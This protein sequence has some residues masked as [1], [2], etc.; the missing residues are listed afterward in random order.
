MPAVSPV[1]RARGRRRVCSGGAA[2]FVAAAP[3]LLWQTPLAAAATAGTR[4]IT[5]IA[6]AEWDGVGGRTLASVQRSNEVRIAMGWRSLV[7]P[8]EPA[9]DEGAVDIT[10][11]AARTEAA[12]GD[13]VRYQ[14]TLRNAETDRTIVAVRLRDALPEVMRLRPGS[15]KVVGATGGLAFRAD[16]RGFTL[17]LPAMP[18]AATVTVSYAAEVRAD[19]RPGAAVNVA[20]VEGGARQASANAVV[21]IAGDEIA[22]RL[23]IIGRVSTGPCPLR[24]APGVPNVRVMLEDGSY[25]VTD[26]DGRYHFEGVRPGLHVV[27]AD[28][29]TLTSGQRF[30]D[31]ERNTRAA[32]RGYSRFVEG[33]GGALKRVDFRVEGTPGLAASATAPGHAPTHPPRPAVAAD[34]AAAGGETDWLVD[35]RP[36]VEWL[37]PA[38]DHNPRA[39]VVRVAIKHL[40]GQKL[41]LFRD[42]RPVDASAFD[43][44]RTSADGLVAISTW[45]GVAFDKGRTRL[46]AEVADANGA[47]VQRLTRDVHFSAAP[48]F[49]QLVPERSRLVA[50]GV[51][52]PV[53]AVRFTDRR[54]RPVHHG[55]VGAFAVPAPYYPAVAADA[56]QARQLAGLER[57]PPAWRVQGDDGVAYLE[58]EPTTASG[59]LPV[60]FDFQDG[61]RR[62][63]QRLDLWLQPGR[64]AWTVVGVAEGTVAHRRLSRGIE[65]RA[66]DGE[67][68]LTDGR[69]A[70]YAKGRVRGKWLL[71]LSYDSDKREDETRFPGVIDPDAYYTVYADRSER[72]YDAASVR[73]LYL[74]IERPQF[75]ALFG[76]YLTGLDEPQLTRYARALNGGKAE[77]RGRRVAATAFAA[78]VAT[79]HRRAELQGDGLSGPYL[80]GAGSILPNSEVVR[81]EVRDRLRSDRIVETRPLVRYANYDIDYRRG[82][83]R[84]KAPLLSRTSGLDPQFLVVDYEVDGVAGRRWHAGGRATVRAMSDRLQLGATAFRDAGEATLAE[85][86]AGA[87]L[88]GGADVR[89][90]PTPATELRA[91]AAV[92]RRE[93]EDIASALLVEAEHHGP[94]VDLL[95]YARRQESGFGVGQ[96]NRAEQGRQ[97]IGADGRVRL[98][99]RLAIFASG[100]T[101]RELDGDARRLAARARVEYAGEERSLRAGL[102]FADD[103]LRDGRG[104]RSTLLE[105]GGTQ[106]LLNNRLELDATSELAL[107]G[108]ASVDFPS[109]HVFSARFRATDYA[110]LVAGY[111]IAD[112]D[113]VSARTARLGFDL[114]PW[115]GARFAASANRQDIAEYGPRS[116][117]AFGLAQSLQLDARWTVDASVDANR[118][119]GGV[120]PARVLNPDQPVATGGFVGD[121]SLFTEDFTAVTAGATYRAGRWSAT[122]RAEYRAGDLGDR[123][124][125][126]L[127]AIR[128]LGEGSAA[129]GL[130]TFFDASGSDGAA[131]RA[132]H[133]QL[134]WAHRPANNGWSWLEKLE[135]HEDRVSNASVGSP[136][137]SIGGLFGVAGDLRSRRLVNSL[138]VHRTSGDAELALFWGSRY[139]S[140]RLGDDDVKGW[141][142]LFGADLRFDLSS[143]VDLGLA[144]TF[145]Q[146]AGDRSRAFAVGPTIGLSPL[147]NGWLQLGWNLLGFRDRDFGDTRYTRSGPFATMRLKF[148]QLSLSG[149]GR[150]AATR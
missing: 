82:T 97:K 150:G 93:G 41:R 109:R 23:T 37:F 87:T 48:L 17:N 28:P 66:D 91:E 139:A 123:H 19:A 13:L 114:K 107:D 98:T 25:A 78:D 92:S 61:D 64:G 27:Q 44:V 50:D 10:K 145:R 128:Q 30:I 90:R 15:L 14:I 59:A 116:F 52:R 4:Y 65:R 54:G 137:P 135:I 85:G 101:E 124:G 47:L 141:S 84:L 35:Q 69:L 102:I 89:Y 79:R 120:G 110:T 53:I 63:R 70:L 6:R 39:P 83:I 45:R 143:R 5:N 106:R 113:A 105:L 12:P 131:A 34:G 146:G 31:C 130:L 126:T 22:E 94:R 2:L 9:A 117:A 127:G 20:T 88:V 111:E 21:R 18:R 57:T 76:D 96:T 86:G 138:S 36:G 38:P 46:S 75:Y 142:N 122:G 121:G 134:S 73:K 3:L 33:D 81:V 80:L 7:P 62:R 133:L 104:A 77:Y 129:G 149:L 71:T 16:G 29:T 99:E 26:T 95:A 32:G 144:A 49:A 125:L 11:V 68:V 67:D 119:L 115:A 136:L 148:D 8:P 103:R 51:T 40:P 132:A 60:E 100:W 118:T 108:D 42:G 74:R 147:D 112:G 43:G 55:L 1:P 24:G 72:R 56:Q 58:L 140:D